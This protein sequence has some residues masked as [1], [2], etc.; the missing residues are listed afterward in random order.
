MPTFMCNPGQSNIVCEEPR[1]K[2]WGIFQGKSLNGGCHPETPLAIRLCSKVQGILAFS[3]K[4]QI[5]L[6][7]LKKY[8]THHMKVQIRRVHIL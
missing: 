3:H 2:L 4:P 6:R 8:N 7:Q 1:S 5:F